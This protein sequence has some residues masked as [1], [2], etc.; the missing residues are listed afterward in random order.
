[1]A[2]DDS[3]T[4]MLPA[5][6]PRSAAGTGAVA[7]GAIGAGRAMPP[8]S[9]EGDEDPYAFHDVPP[10]ERRRNRT[11]LW[12][13]LAVLV[14]LL[15][16]LGGWLLLGDPAGDGSESP[17]TS[18]SAGTSASGEAFLFDPAAYIGLDYREV[19][20]ELE[21]EDLTVTAEA[22]TADQ[23]ASAGRA[24]DDKAVAATDPGT[25]GPLDPGSAVVLYFADGAYAP[26]TAEDSEAP[27]STSE[28]PASTS[29]APE[30]TSAAPTSSS[31]APTSSSA[32]ATSSS[33]S[34]PASGSSEP[35]ATSTP[36]TTETP[37]AG[38][39]EEPAG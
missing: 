8:L 11:W 24:L 15:L 6:G 27:A 35:P 26:P 23:L 20:E 25:A 39:A 4:R 17:R 16:G 9:T 10:E 21:A 38:Q 29:E 37:V 18:A 36:P 30:T 22:A 5:T 33:S 7:T 2:A 28:A 13:A 34:A 14:A 19:Q 12:I 3:S 1:M 31:A 32:A